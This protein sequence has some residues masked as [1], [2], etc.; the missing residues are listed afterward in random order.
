MGQAWKVA[1]ASRGSLDGWSA[2]NIQSAQKC[3]GERQ[4]AHKSPHHLPRLDT[5]ALKQLP[6]DP[7]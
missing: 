6:T 2:E 3:D 1:H 7:E 5:L 4:G